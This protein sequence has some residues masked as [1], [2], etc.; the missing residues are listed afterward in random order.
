MSA[1]T[2]LTPP[3]LLRWQRQ[4]VAIRCALHAQHPTLIRVHLGLGARLVRERLVDD[5]AAHQRMLK[6]LLDTALDEALPWYWRSV[7]L[8]YAVVPLAR[9]QT[10]LRRQDAVLGAE[11]ARALQARVQE[12]HAR[13]PTTPPPGVSEVPAA[14]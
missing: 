11:A 1:R 8:E 2:S 13:L 5:S 10:L 14:R 12:A 7:C 3:Q 4:H 9:L 6:L